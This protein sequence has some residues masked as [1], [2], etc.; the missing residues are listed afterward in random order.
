MIISV[1][2]VDES[3]HEKL[4]PKYQLRFEVPDT[5]KSDDQTDRL[6]FHRQ[7]FPTNIRREASVLED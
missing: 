4:L 5:E 7:V 1:D 2:G 3:V 6:N